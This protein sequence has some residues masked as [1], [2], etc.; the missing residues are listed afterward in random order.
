MVSNVNCAT[1]QAPSSTATIAD[2][3]SAHLVAD[4]HQRCGA[5]SFDGERVTA[6]QGR[7]T[8]HWKLHVVI[9]AEVGLRTEVRR[10]A[11]SKGWGAAFDRTR[12]TLRDK[13]DI[14]A[15]ND[16]TAGNAS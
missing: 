16:R 15:Y 10:P 1:H 6:T 3:E 9:D 4:T 11:A 2:A 13:L 14:E 7:E 5:I 12:T 8:I